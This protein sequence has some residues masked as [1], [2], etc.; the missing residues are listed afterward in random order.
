MTRIKKKAFID[1]GRKKGIS[2]ARSDLKILYKQLKDELDTDYAALIASGL[3]E[4]DQSQHELRNSALWFIRA[5]DTLG[6]NFKDET[7]RLLAM[8][9]YEAAIKNLKN[10]KSGQVAAALS[11]NTA[12]KL[13]NGVSQQ[14]MNQFLA[15]PELQ[16]KGRHQVVKYL[17]DAAALRNDDFVADLYIQAACWMFDFNDSMSYIEKAKKIK[18]SKDI[19]ILELLFDM[20]HNE[21]KLSFDIDW[22][23]IQTDDLLNLIESI[24]VVRATP[25]NEKDLLILLTE[26]GDYIHSK[27]IR[28]ILTDIML[29][30]FN[31]I[32]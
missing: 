8:E 30:I 9:Y 16:K 28:L 23:S 14:W 11:I 6:P 2:D 18:M 29:H 25:N 10:A 13:Q 3:G 12:E 26:L 24:E 19:Q 4:V 27:H 22:E 1:F 32:A 7:D 17:T 5:G 21:E 20:K 15:D 31:K